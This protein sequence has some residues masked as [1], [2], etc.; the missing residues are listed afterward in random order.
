M[1]ETEEIVG[2]VRSITMVF[3]AGELATGPTCIPVIEFAKS[4]G[5]KVPSP[6]PDAA[7]VKLVPVDVSGVNEHPVAVPALEKSEE[8]NPVIV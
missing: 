2:A 1:A 7:M 5:I 6:Q 4:W 3:V 8:A